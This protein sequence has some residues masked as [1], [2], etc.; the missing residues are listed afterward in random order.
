MRR[1][2][3]RRIIVVD[4]LI[5]SGY[6]TRA[7]ID[8]IWRDRTIRSWWSLGYIRV[9]A[10]AYSSTAVG[11]KVV[12][13]CRCRPSVHYEMDCPT[14]DG[15]PWLANKR[16][17]LRELCSA[18]AKRT[19]KSKMPFG[20]GN[21]NAVSVFE[22]GCP[23]NAPAILWAPT[24]SKKPWCPIFPSRSILPDEQSAFPPKIA[25]RDPVNSIDGGKARDL[26]QS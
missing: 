16:D 10:L 18:Y 5:G 1:A 11:A 15:L 13:K 25:R 20:Y 24:T 6:R 8:A 14:I 7:F 3:C 19:S 22:H 9:E 21:I 23:N 2:K 4:D 17:R 26:A 12:G